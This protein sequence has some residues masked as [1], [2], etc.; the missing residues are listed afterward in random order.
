MIARPANFFYVN[1]LQ[2][3]NII[4]DVRRAE[5]EGERRDTQHHNHSGHPVENPVRWSAGHHSKKNTIFASHKVQ[6]ATGCSNMLNQ[7][8]RSLT[9][10]TLQGCWQIVLLSAYCFVISWRIDGDELL[11]QAVVVSVSS[12]EFECLAVKLQ[13]EK[14]RPVCR[15]CQSQATQVFTSWLPLAQNAIT[16]AVPKC[17]DVAEPGVTP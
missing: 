1:A 7:P 2:A 17:R 5:G 15:M 4:W 12:V 11:L 14:S 8:P 10:R 16:T 9:L 3:C 13:C 6:T